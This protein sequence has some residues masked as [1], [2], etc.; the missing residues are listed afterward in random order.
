MRTGKKFRMTKSE[1]PNEIRM[2]KAECL[3][4]IRMIKG[5]IPFVSRAWAFIRGL[6][7]RDAGLTG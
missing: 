7:L 1:S 4:E 6:G 5:E 2:T 3:N